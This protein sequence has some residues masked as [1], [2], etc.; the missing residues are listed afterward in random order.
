MRQMNLKFYFSFLEARYLS[1]F[2]FMH[3]WRNLNKKRK[4]KL[5]Y[6][7]VIQHLFTVKDIYE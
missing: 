1:L 4:L 2:F 5:R 3:A 7:F 6:Y